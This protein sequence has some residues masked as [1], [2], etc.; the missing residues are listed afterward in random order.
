MK[1]HLRK[2]NSRAAFSLVEL[3]VVVLI[4]GILAAVAAPRMFDTA[5]NARDAATKASLGVVRDAIE[6]HRSQNGTYPPV[7]T[8]ATALKP[9]MKGTFPSVQTTIATNQ[10][11]TVVG[12]SADPIVVVAGAAGWVYNATTGEFCVNHASCLAW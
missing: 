6:L 1:S 9:Y 5:G 4:I 12:S 10:N 7:A 8:L 11:N 2:K 3:V